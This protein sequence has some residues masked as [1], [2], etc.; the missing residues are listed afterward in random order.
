M[1]SPVRPFKCLFMSVVKQG[2][3]TPALKSHQN[4]S[5][6]QRQVSNKVSFLLICVSEWCHFYVRIFWRYVSREKWVQSILGIWVC[7]H[8]SLHFSLSISITV[9]Y[10]SSKQL[11]GRIATQ[12][13]PQGVW[14]WF[15]TWIWTKWDNFVFLFETVC[16]NRTPTERFSWGG[17]LLSSHPLCLMG[18]CQ[19]RTWDT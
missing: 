17:E 16:I 7:P 10:A 9:L 13:P 5:Q 11:Q 4:V 1:V 3:K 14:F 18:T 2:G 19:P 15:L 12:K 6:R 8:L